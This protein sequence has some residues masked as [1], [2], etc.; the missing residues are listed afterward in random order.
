[1]KYQYHLG[2]N[3]HH[4]EI[5]IDEDSA[6]PNVTLRY[7]ANHNTEKSIADNHKNEALS[8]MNSAREFI[9]ETFPNIEYDDVLLGSKPPAMKFYAEKNDIKECADSILIALEGTLSNDIE[10][11]DKRGN[12][13]ETE[14]KYGDKSGGYSISPSFNSLNPISKTF[15][16]RHHGGTA[17]QAAVAEPKVETEQP[18]PTIEDQIVR[19]NQGLYLAKNPFSIN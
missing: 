7:I 17:V 19:R 12:A 13:Q 8:A 10:V 6:S 14:A 11:S 16:D 1:M 9:Q 5:E 15:S 3:K 2:E 18:T 4:F